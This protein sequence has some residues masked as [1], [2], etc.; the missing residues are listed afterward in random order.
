MGVIRDIHDQLQRDEGCV[1]HAY[2]D[3]LGYL[4]IGFGRLIDKRRGGG[5]SEAEADM[6][7]Q[8]DIK[9]VVADLDD[10]LPWL[11]QLNDAR[12][13]VFANMAFQMGVAGLLGFHDT[14]ACAERGDWEGTV[15]GL[16]DSKWARQTPDRANRLAAQITTGEWQ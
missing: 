13:G 4:T 12:R 8:N 11:S 10:H 3:H 16:L 5:L 6:L 9:R 15:K 2:Q 1:L 7:L 14:L